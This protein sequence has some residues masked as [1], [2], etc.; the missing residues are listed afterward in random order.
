M[1]DPCAKSSSI[2]CVVPDGPPLWRC[3]LGF[4]AG[5]LQVLLVVVT[6]VLSSASSVEAARKWRDYD[7][8]V[9]LNPLLGPEYAQ[10]LVGPIARIA[11]RDEVEAFLQLADDTAAAEFVEAFWSRRDDALKR[12][13]DERCAEADERYT[14]AAYQGCR[15]DRGTV[16]VLYGDPS[17]EDFDIAPYRGG[18]PLIIWRYDRNAEEGLDGEEPKRKYDFI[19]EG[20]LTTFFKSNQPRRQR[21]QLWPSELPQD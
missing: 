12:T 6:L 4:R 18:P 10:W 19:R 20:D 13:F 21:P 16:Y 15:T 3:R 7:P 14:E 9:L 8:A 17:E 1:I 11:D 2:Y 5:P